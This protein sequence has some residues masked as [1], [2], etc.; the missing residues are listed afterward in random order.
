MSLNASLFCASGVERR[1]GHRAP[2]LPRSAARKLRFGR[3]E[4]FSI[5]KT[6]ASRR[7]PLRSLPWRFRT[8]D[9]AAQFLSCSPTRSTD[10]SASCCGRFPPIIHDRLLLRLSLWGWSPPSDVTGGSGRRQCQISSTSTPGFMIPAGSSAPFAAANALPN[11]SG[12]CARYQ[13]MWSRPTA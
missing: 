5:S 10:C 2:F 12:R 9:S 1:R 11:R 4:R 8:A 3:P 6:S 13:G 7:S